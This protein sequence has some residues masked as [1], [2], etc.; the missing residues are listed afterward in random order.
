MVGLGWKIEP[1]AHL[2]EF[3]LFGAPSQI[4]LDALA[5][6]RNVILNH[7]AEL[8]QVMHSVFEGLAFSLKVDSRSRGVHLGLESVSMTIGGRGRAK[9]NIPRRACRPESPRTLGE[10]W[11]CP[12]CRLCLR[13]RM[14]SVMVSRASFR[15]CTPAEVISC[16][17]ER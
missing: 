12:S 5:D 13:Y 9:M 10:L 2:S 11:T 3:C 6:C 16:E 8:L 14:V 4:L 15:L 17:A 7:V 1:Y